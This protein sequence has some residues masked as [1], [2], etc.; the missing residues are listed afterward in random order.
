MLYIEEE[1][2]VPQSDAF[3]TSWQLM[4]L[5]NGVKLLQTWMQSSSYDSKTK[6]SL[7]V[8][9]M[10][11]LEDGEEMHVDKSGAY[12]FAKQRQSAFHHYAIT[13]LCEDVVFC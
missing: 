13:N 1:Q 6:H 2:S 12:W 11:I 7:K 5:Q 3:Q 9:A 8:R 4:G 10:R